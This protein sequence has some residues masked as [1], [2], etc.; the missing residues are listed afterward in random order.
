[1]TT[2]DYADLREA[3]SLAQW[4]YAHS[5]GIFWAGETSWQDRHRAEAAGWFAYSALLDEREA[6]IRERDE[7][8]M[9]RKFRDERAHRTLV[10]GELN[11]AHLVSDMA[12]AEVESLRRERDEARAKVEV[13]EA[14]LPSEC[15]V[16]RSD[17]GLDCT[18]L[19]GGGFENGA[20]WTAEMCCMPCRIRAALA[21]GADQ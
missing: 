9:A 4:L 7:W 18:A 2:P 6:L 3:E 15:W 11:A 17:V 8:A 10:E 20:K 12:E 19:I 13:V 21:D 1:M 5:G 16:T 14:L